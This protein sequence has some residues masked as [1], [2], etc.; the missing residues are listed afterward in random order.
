M[1]VYKSVLRRLYK[2]VS[3][4]KWGKIIIKTKAD[5]LIIRYK[6]KIYK[7]MYK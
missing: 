7:T 1:T 4:E 6:N 2:T 5:I 3:G